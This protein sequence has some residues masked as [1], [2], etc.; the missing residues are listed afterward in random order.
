MVEKKTFDGRK[1]PSLS[2]FKQHSPHQCN[3]T[4]THRRKILM[5]CKSFFSLAETEDG[6]QGSVCLETRDGVSLIPEDAGEQ[7]C[8]RGRH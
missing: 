2:H 3:V 6:E 7:G 8:S 1:K 5:R 4:N